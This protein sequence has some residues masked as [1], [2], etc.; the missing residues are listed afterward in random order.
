MNQD[1][2]LSL[3]NYQEV[4]DMKLGKRFM[5]ICFVIAATFSLNMTAP[6]V[7]AAALTKG[8]VTAKALNVR[9]GPGKT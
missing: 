6:A 1:I 4:E 7:S 2:L 9:S 5:A 8:T 3:T